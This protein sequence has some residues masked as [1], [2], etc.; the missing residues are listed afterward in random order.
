MP[1]NSMSAAMAVAL[2]GGIEGRRRL[3][4]AHR[5]RGGRPK[6][7]ERRADAPVDQ[8]DAL[9]GDRDAGDADALAH[10]VE[11][12]VRAVRSHGRRPPQRRWEGFYRRGRGFT[13]APRRRVGAGAYG[14]RGFTTAPRRRFYRAAAS[15][16]D[17]G[18][19]LSGRPMRR[20]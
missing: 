19:R 12:D 16:S 11:G 18:T 20:I 15:S 7:P 10:L 2:R 14:G 1:R 3:E 6:G 4:P 13:T 8:A 9:F 5:A 17:S